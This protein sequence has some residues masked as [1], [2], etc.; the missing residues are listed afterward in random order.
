MSDPPQFEKGYPPLLGAL[1]SR[2]RKLN[3]EEDIGKVD[4]WAYYDPTLSYSE[5]IEKFAEAYPQYKWYEE[6]A[7][8]PTK[9]EIKEEEEEE[10]VS[11]V[12]YLASVLKP[13]ELKKE[14]IEAITKVAELADKYKKQYEKTK[15]ELQKIKRIE[16][17]EKKL[18]EEKAIPPPKPK[19]ITALPE[20]PFKPPQEKEEFYN[21]W[22]RIY[23][24]EAE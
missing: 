8:A 17:E 15:E 4:W 12:S 5:L 3:P 16:E 24:G 14:D 13:N 9:K 1:R 2:F 22:M 23:R 18:I 10:A 19:P 6:K 11:Y 20:Y 7:V 21:L